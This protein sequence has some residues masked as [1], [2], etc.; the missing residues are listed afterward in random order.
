MPFVRGLL[1]VTLWMSEPPASW[2]AMWSS[3]FATV[4]TMVFITGGP[5]ALLLFLFGLSIVAL[6]EKP[7]DR[8]GRTPH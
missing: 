8:V 1:P 6:D 4:P 7:Y 3:A 2:V 5:L